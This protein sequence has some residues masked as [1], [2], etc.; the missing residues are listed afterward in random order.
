MA[1]LLPPPKRQ[2][3]YHGVPK[4]EPEPVA[5][6][7]NVVVQF[8]SEDDG[9][10]LAPAVNLP[11][12]V[13]R[14]ALEALVNKLSTK[15][16]DPVPFAFHIAIPAD[17]AKPGAPTR[18]TISKSIEAD[19]LSH[20]THAFTPEDVFVIYCAPQSVFKV[21]PATRCSS[22][23]SGKHNY[24]PGC[25]NL[26]PQTINGVIERKIIICADQYIKQVT[27]HPSSVPRSHRQETCWLLDQGTQMPVCGI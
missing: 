3:L 26:V 10:Q 5:Q 22:T 16:E 21:R 25:I 4:P 23:L 20:P 13:S 19:V 14:D 15:D 27:H 9:S 1:T 17:E 2:K 8:V 6:S 7:P 24:S 12:S 11:A 18:I